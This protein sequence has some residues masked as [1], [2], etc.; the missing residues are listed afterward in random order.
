MPASLLVAV[1][2]GDLGQELL[3]QTELCRAP[4]PPRGRAGDTPGV[5]QG[6]LDAW[7]TFPMAPSPAGPVGFGNV[8]VVQEG[9]SGVVPSPVPGSARGWWLSKCP[10]CAHSAQ[11]WHAQELGTWGEGECR[12]NPNCGKKPQPPQKSKQ[13]LSCLSSREK[14]STFW[15]NLPLCVRGKT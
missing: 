11:C 12:K 13:T 5:A 1:N 14:T 8:P 2:S 7:G 4:L 15:E 10:T 6:A 3:L 9:I